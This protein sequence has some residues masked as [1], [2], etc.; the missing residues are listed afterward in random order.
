MADN[1][2][3]RLH[4]I[5]QI[6]KGQTNAVSIQ[7]MRFSRCT[8]SNIISCIMLIPDFKRALPFA[9]TSKNYLPLVPFNQSI[10]HCTVYSFI[11]PTRG[12]D[13]YVRAVPFFLSSSLHPL[14]RR[15]ALAAEACIHSTA[16]LLFV[17][18]TQQSP[19]LQGTEMF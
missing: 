18:R 16:N 3:N 12:W 15:F 8:L 13:V 11:I 17:S 10:H 14:W 7:E 5:L 19:R 4:I 1:F 2:P 9:E 6:P